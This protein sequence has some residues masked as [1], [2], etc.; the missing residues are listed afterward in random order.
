M[1]DVS[2]KSLRGAV[3]GLS[4]GV[5]GRHLGDS[6]EEFHGDFRMECSFEN[7]RFKFQV[8][9]SICMYSNI[10]NRGL[11]G[12][13]PPSP[14]AV[15]IICWSVPSTLLEKENRPVNNQKSPYCFGPFEDVEV[16]PQKVGVF[17]HQNGDHRFLLFCCHWQFMPQ[18]VSEFEDRLMKSWSE[19][20]LQNVAIEFM[21]TE[22]TE[23]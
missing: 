16:L 21:G 23:I 3:L 7:Q 2:T 5:L 22:M 14:P 9:F 13:K 12:W 1:H 20:H 18:R 10:I 17:F 6:F 15:T 4:L 11:P 8:P 19:V